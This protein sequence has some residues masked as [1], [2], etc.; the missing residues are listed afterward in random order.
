MLQEKQSIYFTFLHSCHDKISSELLHSYG[1]YCIDIILMNLRL[2]H[3]SQEHGV[4][5]ELILMP[6]HM[7]RLHAT[8]FNFSV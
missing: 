2:T 5:L 6:I 8:I 3:W 1:W 4:M 7:L